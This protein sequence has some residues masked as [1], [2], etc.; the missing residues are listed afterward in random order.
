MPSPYKSSFRYKGTI[1]AKILESTGNPGMSA[2]GLYCTINIYLI[3]QISVLDTR[4]LRFGVTLLWSCLMFMR[5]Y[6]LVGALSVLLILS[7]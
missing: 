1:E 5:D 4:S 7:T 2:A 6:L 3:I